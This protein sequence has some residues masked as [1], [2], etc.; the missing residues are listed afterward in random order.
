MLDS[1][2]LQLTIVE[3]EEQKNEKDADEESE[4]SDKEK[5]I[6]TQSYQIKELEKFLN[7]AKTDLEKER[8]IRKQTEKQLTVMEKE[9]ES[10]KSQ[11]QQFEKQEGNRR[12]KEAFDRIIPPSFKLLNT[13]DF[14]IPQEVDKEE[15]KQSDKSERRSQRLK[16][17]SPPSM[18][19]RLKS[20]KRKAKVDPRY[21]FEVI[22]HKKR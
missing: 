12:M 18:V 3:T 21:Q 1:S 4:L 14:E 19:K 2:K 17:I 11:I 16:N 9:V 20:K 13:Q 5:Q 10:L 8:Q 7:Q 15:V 6:Q 22:Y